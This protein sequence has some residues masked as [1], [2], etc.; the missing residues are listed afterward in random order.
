[1]V[2]YFAVQFL[3]RSIDSWFDTQIEQALDDALLLGRSTL[4]TIKLDLVRQ[5]RISARRIETTNTSSQLY[6][7]M[8]NLREAGGYDEMSLHS[9]TGRILASSSNL[10]ISLIPDAPNEEVLGKVRRDKLYAEFEPASDIGLRLR[11]ACSG[12]WP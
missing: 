12:I 2:Y 5:A 4:E 10:S 1:M 3:S 8:D 9:S 7:L 11:V 6:N